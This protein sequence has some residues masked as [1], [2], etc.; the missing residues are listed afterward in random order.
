VIVLLVNVMTE[1]RAEPSF[2]V[3]T[4]EKLVGQDPGVAT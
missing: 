2:R 3:T 4:Y 1:G